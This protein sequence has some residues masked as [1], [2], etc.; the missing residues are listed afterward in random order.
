MKILTRLLLCLTCCF[1]KVYAAPEHQSLNYSTG[2]GSPIT[3]T[4][5]DVLDVGGWSL[6]QRAEY[7]ANKPLSDLTL[8]M[9]PTAESQT[10]AFVNYF[11][12]NYGLG[13]KITVGA[14]LPY[15]H[16]F[17]LR[18]IDIEDATHYSFFD[19]GVSGTSD[20]TL[21]SLVQ[22]K[23][24]EQSLL[25]TGLLLGTNAPTGKTTV[26]DQEGMLLSAADQP[27]SGGWTPFGG[28]IVSKSWDN[29]LLAG[30]LL[31]S[32]PLKGSQQTRLGALFD[33]NF[34]A[35]LEIHSDKKERYNLDAVVELLGEFAEYNKVNGIIETDSGGKTLFIMP[36]LRANVKSIASV[37]FGVGLPLFE[38]YHGVQVTTPYFAIGGVDLSF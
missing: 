10:G 29:F 32:Y 25:S 27:G 4:T 12:V 22:I 8:L 34:A 16:T 23:N 7:Y 30:N 14:S 1:F 18:A 28:L 17:R 5:A 15:T 24:E 3:T 38:R 19:Q 2:I 20:A 35:A 37:Y 9:H 31:Y 6:N 21:Y 13:E 26:R 11:M 36:G 33:Y